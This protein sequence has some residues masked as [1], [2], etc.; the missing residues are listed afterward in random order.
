MK[1]IKILVALLILSFI[2]IKIFSPNLFSDISDLFPSERLIEL[3]IAVVGALVGSYLFLWFV[4]KPNVR[5]SDQICFQKDWVPPGND[6]VPPIDIYLIKLVNNSYF[7]AYDVSF[8]VSLLHKYASTEP[9]KP[10]VFR[11]PLELERSHMSYVAP[12]RFV[13]KRLGIPKFLVDESAEFA[14][15][16][17]I[18]DNLKSLLGKDTSTLRLQVTLSHGLS[19]VKELFI[20]EY[21]GTLSIVEGEFKFGRATG[22]INRNG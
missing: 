16:L 19:G 11:R 7:K 14:F 5:F 15:R 4:L 10:N 1:T 8:E 12:K 6:S 20:K 13:K 17:R 9:G 21:V 22:I 18:N 2:F 3:F